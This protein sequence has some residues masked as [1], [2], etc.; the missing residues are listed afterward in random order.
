MTGATDSSATVVMGGQSGASVKAVA[1]APAL[2]PSG[3][4]SRGVN[5]FG[6]HRV[7]RAVLPSI[8]ERG[9]GTT[10]NIS[11][12]YGRTAM[13]GQG[14]Y[15]GS[16]FALE[17]LSDTL[18]GGLVNTGIDVVLVEP[19]PVET[20]FGNVALAR[21]N[22]LER[23]GACEW[24]TYN[25]Y[26]NRKAVDRAPGLVQPEDVAEVV[27]RAAS[28]AEPDARH[29]VGPAAK[30]VPLPNLVPDR[31]W[32]RAMGLSSGCSDRGR[33][34]L[35]ANPSRDPRGYASLVELRRRK[36]AG[37]DLNSLRLAALVSSAQIRRTTSSLTEGE[38]HARRSPLLFAREV[39]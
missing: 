8:R 14:A 3:R 35:A 22:D 20:D 10:I 18:R 9:D 29:L 15:C 5:T 19:G 1:V 2:G 32:D 24:F 38:R 6:P 39:R 33:R 16:K 23:T 28:A 13:L 11:S 12:V 26:D 21:K 7:T 36:R 25:M 30:P 4:P 27:V 37:G 17:A 31:L 34:T